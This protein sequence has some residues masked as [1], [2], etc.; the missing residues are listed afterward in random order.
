MTDEPAYVGPPVRRSGLG[1]TQA[2]IDAGFL[3]PAEGDAAYLR[4]DGTT[5]M[6]GQVK[7]VD[8][9]AGAPSYTFGSELDTGMY[10]AAPNSLGFAAAGVLQLVI[11]DAGG[12][13]QFS[14][15]QQTTMQTTTGDLRVGA[16]GVEML[17]LIDTGDLVRVV[18]ATTR[19]QF[20][21]ASQA[22]PTPG[23]AG[24]AGAPPATPETYFKVKNAAGDELLIPAYL[25]PA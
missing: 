2:Q 12:A 3:T 16:G 25:S 24:A 4:L 10:L 9:T 18:G 22:T 1:L 5:V 7:A 23:G 21:H 11:I 19:L 15:T 13:G 17:S 6:V 14:F 8:G 20:G